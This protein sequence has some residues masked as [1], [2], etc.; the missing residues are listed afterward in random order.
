VVTYEQFWREGYWETCFSGSCSIAHETWTLPQLLM[1]ASGAGIQLAAKTGN[2]EERTLHSLG[3][4]RLWKEGFV[5]IWRIT[6]EG[7]KFIHCEDGQRRVMEPPAGVHGGEPV[8]VQREE[9]AG[10][11]GR[12]LAGVQGGEDAGVQGGEPAGVQGGEHAGVQ[13][14]EPAGGRGGEPAGVQGGEHA[15]VQRE[16][17][18]GGR[19]GEHAGVQG[20]EHAGVQGGEPAWLGKMADSTQASVEYHCDLS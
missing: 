16:E 9:P 7:V 10:V 4:W 17:P 6:T 8:G 2:V 11:Q 14:E 18:A 13:R 5:W 15:G 12:D 20:G 1:P 3:N 19:G